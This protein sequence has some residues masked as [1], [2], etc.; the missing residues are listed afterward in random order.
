M[1]DQLPRLAWVFLVLSMISIGGTN[2]VLPQMHHD[3]VEYGWVSDRQFADLYAI[4][5]AA[6]GPSTLVVTLIGF[7]AAGLPGA[8]VATL[9]TILPCLTF[10]YLLT[11]IWERARTSKWRVAVERGLAPVTVGL[12]FASGLVL[13]KAAD[14]RLG[15]FVVTGLAVVIFLRTKINP[16][17][18]IAG[19]AVLGLLGWI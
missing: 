15:A 19:C 7:K 2:T 11:R 5:Q 4:A 18:V 14:H 17:V 8:V 6:P 1:N 3:A 10:T 13:A 9:A 16:L 12:I